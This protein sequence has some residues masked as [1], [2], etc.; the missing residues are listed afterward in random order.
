MNGDILHIG[1]NEYYYKVRLTGEMLKIS[2]KLDSGMEKTLTASAPSSN[3]LW[4]LANV[5][6]TDSS[7]TL[8]LLNPNG[9]LIANVTDSRS[10]NKDLNSIVRAIGNI[11]LGR[12]SYQGC[13]QQVRIQEILLPFYDDNLFINNTSKERFLLQTAN[14]EHGCQRNSGCAS[15]ECQ[16][17]SSCV[18]DYYT[19]TCNCSNAYTG[20][21][22]QDYADHCEAGACI[23]GICVN[24]PDSYMCKCYSGYTGSR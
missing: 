3:A 11:Q 6:E 15:S 22:C 12:T 2:Y 19:Y 5:T 21:W 1:N 16:H 18:E 24:T 20:R 17:A 14:F 13:L 7:V 23:N 10:G 9:E 4:Y 8:N